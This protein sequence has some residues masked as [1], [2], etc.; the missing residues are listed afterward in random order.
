MLKYI[1]YKGRIYRGDF[2]DN[3]RYTYGYQ[4]GWRV[5]NEYL[6]E[7]NSLLEDYNAQKEVVDNIRNER[8][9][10]PSSPIPTD[11]LATDEEIRNWYVEDGIRMSFDAYRQN[12]REQEQRRLEEKKQEY[13]SDV[14]QAK[15]AE[16]NKNDRYS[17][18]LYVLTE[19]KDV[20]R[21]ELNRQKRELEF[22]LPRR[23]MVWPE[24]P[25]KKRKAGIPLP[26]CSM[27]T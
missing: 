25:Q 26:R 14:I 1:L 19:V 2:M 16:D 27:D 15:I 3:E 20:L 4:N 12:F 7:V 23:S 5:E 13:E 6:S 18:N 24:G 10:S 9:E 8:V 17:A 21:R 11:D 22:P